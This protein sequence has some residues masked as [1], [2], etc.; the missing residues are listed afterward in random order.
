MGDVFGPLIAEGE[1][2]GLVRGKKEG[3]N[4]MASFAD[5]LLSEGRVEDLKY[6]LKNEE[7]CEKLMKEILA[8]HNKTY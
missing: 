4:R 6:A 3:M 8:D 1:A 5:I 2:R 7:Y